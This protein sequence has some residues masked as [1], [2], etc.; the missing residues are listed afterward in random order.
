MGLTQLARGLAH[1]LEVRA[2]MQR[3]DSVRV[4]IGETLVPISWADAV[5][6]RREL[7]RLGYQKVE[8]RFANV[9]TT[10]PVRINDGD[11]AALRAALMGLEWSPQLAALGELAA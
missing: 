9:G 11:R 10:V 5:A 1:A 6:L 3:L 4:Q 8:K 2:D 7:V